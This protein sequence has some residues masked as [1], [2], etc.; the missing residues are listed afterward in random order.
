MEVYADILIAVNFTVDYFLLAFT[1]KLLRVNCPLWR[2]L[3]AAAV[4]A[5]SSLMIFLPPLGAA[6]EFIIRIVLCAVIAF[7]CFGF[8]GLRPFIRA[9][10]CFF[11]V[12]F[13]FAGAML[14]VWYI[15]KPYGM[16]INNSAVYFNVSPMFLIIFSVVGYFAAAVLRKIFSK[17]APC[18]ERCTVRFFLD[19]KSTECEA[20]VDSGNS[21]EDIFGSGEIIIA[22][23]ATARRIFG[24][25][26]ERQRL[27]PRYRAIPCSGVAGA[28]LLDGWRCDK[29]YI[30]CG[31]ERR[32]LA[33]PIIAVSK[34]PFGG[35]Y[36]AIINPRSL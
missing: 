5:A 25:E 26:N 23:A 11:A 7:V 36:G 31:G 22:D 4:A 1:A 13:G 10:I 2:Q 33:R 21:L 30:M 17:N 9:S 18:A 34:E 20:I 15:F 27:K 8:H 29:A 3:V 12:S 6:I 14:A 35:D 16:V 28:G 32:E 24:E 19:G